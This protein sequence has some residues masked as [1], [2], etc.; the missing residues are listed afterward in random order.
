MDGLDAHFAF[1]AIA[2][3]CH[4]L[5]I[6]LVALLVLRARKG[7]LSVSDW[8]CCW[9]LGSVPTW[10][11]KWRLSSW[12]DRMTQAQSQRYPAFN[13]SN[14]VVSAFFNY[15]SNRYHTL[16]I[17]DCC[18]VGVVLQRLIFGISQSSHSLKARLQFPAMSALSV[19]SGQFIS[20]R[21]WRLDGWRARG[22][23]GP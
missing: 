9:W 19:F 21:Q 8:G 2:P 12:G 13:G 23:S 7:H 16:E 3:G 17:L 14:Q 18:H 20:H 10:G 6:R 15:I 5:D 11:R 4:S 1:S 22:Q